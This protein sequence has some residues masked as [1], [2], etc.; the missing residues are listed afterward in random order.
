MD[1][2]VGWA[3]KAASEHCFAWALVLDLEDRDHFPVFFASAEELARYRQCVISESKL[4]IQE[5]FF[6]GCIEGEKN[7]G[8][9]DVGNN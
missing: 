5:V 3:E 4:Q 9:Q 1:D 7:N 2:I 8:G 6:L